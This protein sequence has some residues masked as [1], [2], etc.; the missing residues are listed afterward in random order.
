MYF[1]E[2][3][4]DSEENH[5]IYGEYSPDIIAEFIHDKKIEIIGFYK[6]KLVKEPEFIGIKNISCGEILSMI[7]STN[8]EEKLGNS[9]YKLNFEQY[10][11]FK[12]MYSELNLQ[13]NINI[14]NNLTKKIF[15]RIYV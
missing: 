7:E 6:D 15:N 10:L 8:K 9:D 14:F 12:N 3:D 5:D 4:Y 1:E 11:L 2:N 13:V